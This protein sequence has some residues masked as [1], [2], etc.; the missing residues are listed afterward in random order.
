MKSSLHLITQ[1]NDKNGQRLEFINLSNAMINSIKSFGTNTESPL[2]I[3]FCPMAND[4]K[5]AN[6]I[7]QK[8]ILSTHISET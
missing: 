7:S 6:W 3:Q 5:G 4:N 8:K 1:A 2:Y